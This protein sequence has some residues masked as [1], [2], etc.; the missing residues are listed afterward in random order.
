[1]TDRASSAQYRALLTDRKPKG[2]AIHALGRL[3]AGVMNATEAAYAQ[4]LEMRRL[5][6]EVAWYRFEAVTFHLARKTSYRPD[7][8]VMLA[9]GSLECHEVKGARGVF[10]EDAKAR[11]KIAAD[12][13][14]LRFFVAYPANREKTEWDVKDVDNGL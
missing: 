4:H 3:P 13:F 14:P 7:F 10:E 9:D 12:I 11:C 5:G 2:K 8:L 1:M 6:G